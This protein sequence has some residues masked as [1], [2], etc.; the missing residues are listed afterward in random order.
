MEGVAESLQLSGCS[1]TN[2]QGGKRNNDLGIGRRNCG[3]EESRIIQEVEFEKEIQRS[4][5]LGFEFE[6]KRFSVSLLIAAR[7]LEHTRGHGD[8]ISRLHLVAR[9]RNVSLD[10]SF[11]PL[12]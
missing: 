11:T 6:G 1:E 8:S 10:T 9:S 7:G 12:I 3:K 2:R 4:V 5:H